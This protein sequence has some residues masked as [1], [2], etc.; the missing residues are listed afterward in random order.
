MEAWYVPNAD[1]QDSECSAVD[2]PCRD[3]GWDCKTAPN[4]AA[5]SSI[6]AEDRSGGGGA[7]LLGRISVPSPIACPWELTKGGFCHRCAA[8]QGA[9]WR[10]LME[11]TAWVSTLLRPSKVFH[12]SWTFYKSVTLPGSGLFV[13]SGGLGTQAIL[14]GRH[15]QWGVSRFEEADRKET[16]GHKA[17]EK[18]KN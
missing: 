12:F 8:C 10:K 11:S 6:Q 9:F 2:A 4:A 14:T 1:I 18:S 5:V 17:R 7:R 13:V 3:R 15:L 16:E